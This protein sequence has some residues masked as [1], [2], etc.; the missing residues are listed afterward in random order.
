V[1][2]VAERHLGGELRGRIATARGSVWE[3][4]IIFPLRLSAGG[5]EPALHQRVAIPIYPKP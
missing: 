2:W 4:F 3:S 1:T 5:P